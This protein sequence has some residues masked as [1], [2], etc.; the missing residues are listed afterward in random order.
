MQGSSCTTSSVQGF[1]HC[2]KAILKNPWSVLAICKTLVQLQMPHSI[3]P[4]TWPS[5]HKHWAL[6]VHSCAFLG[7]LQKVRWVLWLWTHQ[8]PL[9][10]AWHPLIK[11]LTLFPWDTN[12]AFRFYVWYE[13]RSWGFV[14]RRYMCRDSHLSD[15][16]QPVPEHLIFQQRYIALSSMFPKLADLW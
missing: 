7:S 4:H 9:N 14:N 11:C 6:S 10:W 13:I 12:K 15:T 2:K 1:M 5:C 16:L 3:L 8:I